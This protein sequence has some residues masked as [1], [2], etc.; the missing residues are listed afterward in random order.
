MVNKDS[1]PTLKYA[2]IIASRSTSDEDLALVERVT[3]TEIVRLLDLYADDRLE[4]LFTEFQL[5]EYLKNKDALSRRFSF[6]EPF[7]SILEAEQGYLADMIDSYQWPS[8]VEDIADFRH[9]F[10]SSACQHFSEYLEAYL[11]RLN[12]AAEQAKL[13]LYVRELM[14]LQENFQIPAFMQRCINEIY[15]M[16]ER[17][18]T[19]SVGHYWYRYGL[20]L[21][22]LLDVDDHGQSRRL[23][24]ISSLFYNH[25]D[26]C[27]QLLRALNAHV[28]AT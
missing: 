26:W 6:V 4:H 27:R 14:A 8:S 19:I 20:S 5:A 23:S 21:Q 7:F 18:A 22:E 3:N 12:Q 10:G 2:D 24:S 1:E 28:S 17:I 16:Q 13:P 9:R 11:L 25:R 15:V